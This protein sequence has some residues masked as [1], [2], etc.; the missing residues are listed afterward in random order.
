MKVKDSFL[1]LDQFKLNN[2]VHIRFWEDKWLE[3]FSLQHRFPSL[4]AIVRKKNIY[5]ASVF[6]I[7]PLNISFRRGLVGNN[8]SLWYSL[9]G[10]V[11]HVRLIGTMDSF[12][13]GLHQNCIFSFKSMYSALIVDGMFYH[14]IF[15]LDVSG[16]RLSL[17]LQLGSFMYNK[18]QNG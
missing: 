5:V 15:F 17:F 1:S 18:M 13:W 8:L 16:K 4:Y 12:I 7:V 11:A 2:R 14:S 9:V 10:M 3:N 6:S